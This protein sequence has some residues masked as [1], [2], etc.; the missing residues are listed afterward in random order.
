[1]KRLSIIIFSLYTTAAGFG[2]GIKNT[3]SAIRVVKFISI[4]IRAQ[5]LLTTR[6][7]HHWFIPW[8]ALTN[9]C[10]YGLICEIYFLHNA[11]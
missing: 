3:I 6:R 10:T 4:A 7:I 8:N 11:G 5:Q 9:S 1:M 2:Q